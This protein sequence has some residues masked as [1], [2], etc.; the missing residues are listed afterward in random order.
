MDSEVYEDALSKLDVQ[1]KT[2]IN[3]SLY[4]D[5]QSKL[6]NNSS[7]RNKTKKS[8]SSVYEDAQSKLTSNSIIYCKGKNA[9]PNKNNF[10]YNKNIY[11]SENIKNNNDKK[12]ISRNTQS[13]K[14]KENIDINNDEIYNNDNNN[15]NDIKSQ[16]L[17]E[18]PKE[19]ENGIID[20][21]QTLFEGSNKRGDC[22]NLPKCFI[23]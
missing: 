4:Q 20:K 3:G 22:C 1:S 12:Y 9:I 11:K 18:E 13:K 10:V 17:Y 7:K 21:V 14:G 5:A 15:N 23:F 19:T 6:G 16:S 8:E 2:N